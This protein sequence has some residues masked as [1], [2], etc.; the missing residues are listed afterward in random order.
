MQ[1]AE[2]VKLLAN[3]NVAVPDEPGAVPV[4]IS[5]A[6]AESDE[7]TLSIAQDAPV[8][9]PVTEQV[10][11]GA[12]LAAAKRLAES[13]VPVSFRFVV[14]GLLIVGVLIVGDVSV[15][16]VSVCVSLIPTIAEAGAV[17]PLSSCALRL[18]TTVV[19]AMLKGAVPVETVEI[20]C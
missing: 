10:G 4:L 20:I 9:A 18:G 15:L 12:V 13:C 5:I 6:P 11:L 16:L 14:A 8:P 1:N 19:L 3:V 7:D 2:L 17:K